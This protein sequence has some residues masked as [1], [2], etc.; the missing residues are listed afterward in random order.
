MYTAKIYAALNSK[1]SALMVEEKDKKSNAKHQE[2][3]I[4]QTLNPK[5]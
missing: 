4:S 2:P 1:T 5:P 3:E